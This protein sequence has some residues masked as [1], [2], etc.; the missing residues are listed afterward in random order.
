MP[1]RRLK[2]PPLKLATDET[3]G[4]RLARLR[5]ER[6]LTQTELAEKIGII[7]VLIADYERDKLRLNAEM[8]CR[9][10]KALGV[11]ADILL[12]LKKT[13]TDSVLV[14]NSALSLKLARR[15]QKI[16]QLPGAKQK[17]LLQTI[18]IYL[19]ASGL[20]A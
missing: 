5:K 9:L 20:R 16:D 12:G 1:K 4:Q 13:E 11:S 6:G 17:A 18:D 19:Q 7:Q 15:L 2:L 14:K 8:I 10:A 3:F